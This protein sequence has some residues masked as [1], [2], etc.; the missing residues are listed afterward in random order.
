MDRKVAIVTGSSS[1]IGAAT[2][3]LFAHNGFNV[4]INYSRNSE[5]AEAVAEECRQFGGEALV[6]RC[7]VAEDSDCRSMA[8]AVAQKWGRADALIN[9]AGTTKFAPADDLDAL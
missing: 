5:Q 6:M 4:V 9:N 7:N 2:A 8:A 1:G 3:R